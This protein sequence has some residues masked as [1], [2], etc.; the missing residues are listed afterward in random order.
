[1]NFYPGIAQFNISTDL[2]GLSYL[3][4]PL[5][6]KICNVVSESYPDFSGF[7]SHYQ[8]SDSSNGPVVSSKL[9]DF[10]SRNDPSNKINSLTFS[11]NIYNFHTVTFDIREAQL[12][13]NQH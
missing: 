1:M 9:L 12:F 6:K 10:E 11:C 7:I 8:V 5:F 3:D 4:F 2:D 13:G